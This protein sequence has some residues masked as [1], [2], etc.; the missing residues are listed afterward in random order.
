MMIAA[1]ARAR[2]AG[3]PLRWCPRRWRPPRAW[4]RSPARAASRSAVSVRAGP[5]PPFWDERRGR[6]VAADLVR[7]SGWGSSLSAGDGISPARVGASV[8]SSWSGERS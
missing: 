2:P 7:P 4:R 6:A 8:S 1:V 5:R 3:E